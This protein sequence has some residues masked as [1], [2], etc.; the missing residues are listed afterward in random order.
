MNVKASL[1][2]FYLF[3]V[4]DSID[5]ASLRTVAGEGVMAAPL[6]YRPHISPGYLQFPVPPLVAR[7]PDRALHSSTA[8]TRVKF[9]DY[10]VVSVR[11]SIPYEGDWSGLL[12]LAHSLR[13][14]ETLAAAAQATLE[15]VVAELASVLDDPH[16]FLIEDY[17]I[18]QVN[19]FVPRQSAETLLRTYGADIARL[20]LNEQAALSSS[21]VEESLRARFTYFD[22]DL[23]V[24]QWDTA[25]VYDRPESAEAIEDILEFANSQLVELRT[26]DAQLDREL[27]DIYAAKPVRAVGSIFGRK[28]AEQAATLRYLIVD[29]LELI[30]RSSNALKI[31]GD[32]YYARIYRAAATRLGLADWQK[33]VDAKLASVGDVYRF[34]SDQAKNS[35]DEF[36]EIVIIFLILLEVVIGFLTLRH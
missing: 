18:V 6:P 23:V 12:D 28:A 3:D 8:A 30:D 26:Y 7:L 32:A 9:Y 2:F 11:L 10:G 29:V 5:L 33:Q 4:A 34:L 1:R 13:Q 36:L 14:G 17:L 35:R 20:L 27:D 19:E 15:P 24:I 22:D 16:P 21:E 25:L 31:I